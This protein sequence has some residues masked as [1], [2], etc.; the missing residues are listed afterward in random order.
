MTFDILF[1]TTE[2]KKLYSEATGAATGAA[3]G[4]IAMSAY[5]YLRVVYGSQTSSF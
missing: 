4:G 2:D 1:K 3:T 5:V